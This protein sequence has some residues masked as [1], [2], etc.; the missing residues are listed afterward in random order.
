MKGTVCWCAARLRRLESWRG[1]ALRWSDV[2]L[3]RG[4]LTVRQTVEDSIGPLTIGPTKTY[5]DSGR[6]KRPSF[7]GRSGSQ[8]LVMADVVSVRPHEHRGSEPKV[9]IV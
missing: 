6:H 4:M 7:D 2:D 5:A 1:L 8:G 9:V 3:P